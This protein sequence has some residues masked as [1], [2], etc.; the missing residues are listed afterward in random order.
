MYCLNLFGNEKK[1][2]EAARVFSSR[3][4]SIPMRIE[5]KQMNIIL[6]VVTRSHFGLPKSRD[7]NNNN[8]SEII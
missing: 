1:L 8:V 4:R 6:L 5:T 3:P 7:N 2:N